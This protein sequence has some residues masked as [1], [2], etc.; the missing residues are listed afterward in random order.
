M[1]T[2]FIRFV[3][4][5]LEFRKLENYLLNEISRRNPPGLIKKDRALSKISGGNEGIKHVIPGDL[6]IIIHGKGYHGKSGVVAI[7]KATTRCLN[8]AIDE[9]TPH[10]GPTEPF[11]VGVESIEWIAGQIAT[12]DKLRPA[13]K[14]HDPNLKLDGPGW[15]YSPVDLTECLQNLLNQS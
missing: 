14:S 3:E 11:A 5:G 6:V 13:I 10:L 9:T 2:L 1:G 12:T 15:R 8:Y 4:K 7:G